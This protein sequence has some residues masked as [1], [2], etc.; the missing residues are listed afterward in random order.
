MEQLKTI[1]INHKKGAI[2]IENKNGIKS[3]QLQNIQ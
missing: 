2:Q 1:V 3:V